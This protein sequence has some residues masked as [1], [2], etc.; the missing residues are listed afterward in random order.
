MLTNI[1]K[2]IH[3]ECETRFKKSPRNTEID[4]KTKASNTDDKF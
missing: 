1:P 4:Q 2:L 3:N